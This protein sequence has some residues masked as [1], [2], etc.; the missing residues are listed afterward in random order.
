VTAVTDVTDKALLREGGPV[1][2]G[3]VGAL[4]LKARGGILVKLGV[5]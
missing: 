5:G 4:V 3:D 2:G 1:L